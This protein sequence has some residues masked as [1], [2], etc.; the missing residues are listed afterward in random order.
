MQRKRLRHA[1][2]V[3]AR[4]DPLGFAA[5]AAASQRARLEPPAPMADAGAA[6]GAASARGVVAG[7]EPS[8]VD[9]LGAATSGGGVSPQRCGVVLPA[10]G[11]ALGSA[12]VASGACG[13]TALGGALSTVS[14]T[15]WARDATLASTHSLC[16]QCNRASPR[17]VSHCLFASCQAPM[18]GQAGEAYKATQ[19]RRE[20]YVF[21]SARG[22]QLCYMQGREQET[23][24]LCA[25]RGACERLQLRARPPACLD[26]CP[27]RYRL[28]CCRTGYRGGRC[29][30][31]GDSGGRP[32]GMR[33]AES[34]ADGSEPRHRRGVRVAWFARRGVLRG[35]ARARRRGRW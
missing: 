5:A 15:A 28:P 24:S 19:A 2:V 17:G 21:A 13:A 29:T 26:A 30:A 33:K 27:P 34:K 7:T 22:R 8:V 35:A 16:T 6:A 20:E 10:G 23:D 25:G 31:L 11:G 4:G 32:L 14:A 3:N 1:E 12:A 18:A 9:I